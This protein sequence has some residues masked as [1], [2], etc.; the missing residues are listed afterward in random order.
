MDTNHKHLYVCTDCQKET[1]LGY[2]DYEFECECGS[3]NYYHTEIIICPH[4]GEEVCL[5]SFNIINECDCG[6]IF[7]NFGQ[8]LDNPNNWDTADYYGTFGP[9]NGPDEY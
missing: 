5:N 6:A 1:Q 4:C 3:R 2:E 9:L 8:E 7:N